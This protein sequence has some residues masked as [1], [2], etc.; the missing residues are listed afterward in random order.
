MSESEDV[1][2]RVEAR[3]LAAGQ[4]AHTELSSMCDDPLSF[5]R[6]AAVR[7]ATRHR[8]KGV[9]TA[10][11]R[12]VRLSDFNDRGHDERREFIRAL[13]TLS[14]DRGEPIALELAKRGG[15]FVSE[16]REATRIAAAE[17]LGAVSRS[18]AV[19][20]ELR[21]IAQARWGTS[22]QTR[23]A[24]AT[25]AGLITK[26]FDGRGSGRPGADSSGG[27]PAGAMS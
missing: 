18:P 4:L 5:V 25:A 22:D 7:A 21:E 10:I 12:Q 13:V 14:P 24:A 20:A 15:V 17:A 9:W 27:G 8:I 6:V 19:A 2:V 26:R 16:S 1:N 11:A 23:S 3:V